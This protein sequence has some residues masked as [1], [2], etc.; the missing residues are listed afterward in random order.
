[1]WNS[2]SPGG[3][4]RTSRRSAWSDPPRSATGCTERILMVRVAVNV[5]QLLHEAPGG[6]GRY[7]A[8]L[9]RLLPAHGVDVTPFPARH[10]RTDVGRALHAYELDGAEPVVLPLPAALLYDAWHVLGIAGPVRRVAPVDLVH[11]P[12]PAVPPTGRVPLVVTVH[13]AAPLVMPDAFTRR[14]VTF[15]RRGF[16]VGPRRGRLVS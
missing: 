10:A 14:G 1:M 4:L 15:H 5:E 7:T 16:A 8:E 9:V 2:N 13:D 6:I 3:R 11:A 12:S